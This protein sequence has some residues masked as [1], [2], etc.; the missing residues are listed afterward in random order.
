MGKNFPEREDRI[1][2]QRLS[3]A[4][5]KASG[6]QQSELQGEHEEL[7]PLSFILHEKGPCEGLSRGGV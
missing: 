2:E 6:L 3:R 4:S 1:A 5:K 7:R